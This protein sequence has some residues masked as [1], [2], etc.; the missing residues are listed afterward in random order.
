MQDLR[1]PEFAA[2]M[3]G[4]DPCVWPQCPA[5]E[6]LKSAALVYTCFSVMSDSFT[7]FPVSGLEASMCLSRRSPLHF[8]FFV[9][10]CT[11]PHERQQPR[12]VLPARA[13]TYVATRG[14]GGALVAVLSPNVSDLILLGAG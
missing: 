6:D 3:C 11:I 8:G 2:D 7:R 5:V 14:G 1:H 12:P 4:L 10:R 9:T 13:H